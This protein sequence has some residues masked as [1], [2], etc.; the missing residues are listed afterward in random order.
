[1]I[2]S[3]RKPIKS[4]IEMLSDS[5]NILIA[6]C[7][8][9]ASVCMAGGDRETALL[10]EALQ[11]YSSLHSLNWSI[12]EISVERQCEMEWAKEIADSAEGMDAIISLGCG[13]GVQCIQEVCDILVLPGLNTS[14]MGAPVE[15]GIYAERCGGC[16]DCTLHLTGGICPVARCSKSMLNGPCGGSQNGKCEVNPDTECAWDLIYK[17]LGKLNRLELLSEIIPPKDWTASHSGGPRKIVRKD[18][19]LSD[20]EKKIKEGLE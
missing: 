20:E 15:Q 10:S 17:S 6:G 19:V 1:M 13:V 4:I 11:L 18:M 14:N 8:S 16:G 3:E 7:R 12:S 5:T 9:C 2:I